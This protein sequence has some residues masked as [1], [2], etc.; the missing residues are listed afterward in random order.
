MM[1]T[2]IS[3]VQV[4]RPTVRTTDELQ[5]T[6]TVEPVKQQDQAVSV[7]LQLHVT[8]TL[9]P[10]DEHLPHAIE[11]HVHR[12][13]LEVQRALFRALIEH[14]DRQLVLAGR[15]GDAGRGIQLRGTRPFRFKTLFGT[16]TVDRTRITDRGSRTSRTP[17]ATAWET[18]HRCAL[19]RGLREAICDQMLDESAGA[20][21]RDV[22]EAAAEPGLV[23]RSTV[24]G[25]VHEEGAALLE[26]V[27]A[28][29]DE[30]LRAPSKP[31]PSARA[32]PA[33]GPPVLVELDE[34][35]VKAQPQTGRK[36]IWLFTA[37]VRLAGW[38]H[39][40]VDCAQ[41]GLIR[42]LTAVLHRLGVTAGRR[43]LVV[44]ADGAGW[45]RAWFEAL[46]VPGKVMVLCWYHLRKRCYQKISGSGLPKA[47][48]KPLLGRVLGA[49]WEGQVDEAVRALA[50]ARGA[51]GRP[52]WIDELIN[53]LEARR[54][55][56][57]DYGARKEAGQPLAS[58]RVEKWN[59]WAVSE[60]CKGR[61]MSWTAEGVVALAVLEAARRNGELDAWRRDRELPRL[62]VPRPTRKAA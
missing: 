23:C 46:A 6:V 13:G 39:L 53:Y 12:A 15:R 20:V 33:G 56:L 55:Y 34:V 61:G 44:I 5:A 50:E 25:V 47:A 3:I 49:L 60:R 28:R 37:V 36:E 7:G 14:A 27:R 57:P 35:K 11:A 18:G 51:A 48:K 1:R 30:A 59:D 45:I 22:C 58:H 38:C 21:H 54:R 43:P 26:A 19:T 4:W 41:E 9:P 8:F 17:S 62:K 32:A 10:Q 2:A 40:L 42:R 24:L 31:P 29:A 16:V 52:G